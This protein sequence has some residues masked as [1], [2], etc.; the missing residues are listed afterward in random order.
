MLVCERLLKRLVEEVNVGNSEVRVITNM[1]TVV[2]D[3]WAKSQRRL[4][5]GSDAHGGHVGE[6]R[7]GKGK[8]EATLAKAAPTA[9][10]GDWYGKTP[11]TP[12][13]HPTTPT[14]S[15][16][17]STPSSRNSS[18]PHAGPSGRQGTL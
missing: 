14:T 8:G 5:T 18:P 7:K 17:S 12:A 9:R 10:R 2:M 3:V 4:L 13:G 11:T 1:Y 16:S 15:T 6:D